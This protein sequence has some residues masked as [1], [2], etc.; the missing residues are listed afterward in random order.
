M[1]VSV[2]VYQKKLGHQVEWTTLGLGPHTRTR[3]GKHPYKVQEQLVT[4]L[5]QVIAKL[6]PRDLED[7]QMARGTQLERV[8]VELVLKAG[9]KRKMTGAVPLILEPRWASESQRVIV[10]YHPARQNEWFPVDEDQGLVEQAASFFAASWAELV[11]EQIDE[12]WTDG[13][14]L[15]K[16]VSFT[17]TPPSLLEELPKKARG[18]WDDLKDDRKQKK[19]PRGGFKVLGDIGVNMTA[20]AAEGMLSPGMARPELREQLRLVL[21]AAKKVPA[22]LVGEP[23]SGKTTLLHRGIVDLL[24][25]D[26]Y[27]AH[28]NLDRV[29][30]VWR[31]GG[32]GII[33]GMTYLGDWEQ[34]CV[35]LLEDVRHRKIVLYVE[36]IHQLGRIGRSRDSERNLAEVFRG[37]L[38]RGELVMIGECTPEQLRQLEEDAPAFAAAFTRVHVPPASLSDTFRMMVHEVREL[39]PVH[40]VEIEPTALRAVLELGTTFSSAKALPG[41]AVDLLRQVTRAHAGTEEKVVEI[42][43]K[44]VIMQLAEKTGLPDVLLEPLHPLDPAHVEGQLERR[45]MGQPE[46][47]RA[48]TDLIV[49]IKTGLVDPRRPYGVYLFAGPTGTGKTELAKAIA[50]Y[51]YGSASRLLRLDMSE[52]AT[53]DAAARLIGDRWSPEGLL[54]QRV[55][56][57]PFSVVLFDEIE[58]AHPQV[59]NLLLQLFDE[60]RLTDAAGNTASFT[61]AVV[62]MTS[63]LGARARLPVGFGEEA[64]QVAAMEHVKAVREFFP[65]ELFNRIDRIVPFSPITEAVARRIA[66]KE[67]SRLFSR[68]GLADRSVFVSA[69][70]SVMDRIVREAFDA[71]DGARS[72]KRYLEDTIGTLLTRHLVSGPPAAMQLVR[73]FES[74]G[75]LA[76]LS[77]PL[78]ERDPEDARWALE[79]ALKLAGPELESRVSSTLSFLEDLEKSDDL[80][81][82][83]E[84][85]REHLRR[86][87]LGDRQSADVLYNLETMRAE[88][89][90]FRAKLEQLL[91]TATDGM[92]DLDLRAFAYGYV[93]GPRPVRARILEHM[94]EAHFLKRA[95]RLVREADQHA[96]WLELLRMG[97]PQTPG[98][99][100][101]L[102]EAYVGAR[103]ICEEAAVRHGDRVTRVDPRTVPA[104]AQEVWLKIVGLCVKDFYALE[105]GCHVRCSLAAP[106]EI[107]RVRVVA[108]DPEITTEA[109]LTQRIA[110]RARFQAAL[111]GGGDVPSNPDALTPAV[112]KIQ[113]DPP[114]R[115]GPLATVDIED[116]ALGTAMTLPARRLVDALQPLWLLRMSREESS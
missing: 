27:D 38:A 49:R 92:E 5:R 95:V 9:S 58:K 70:P 37:P 45:V 60:G 94:G 54:T 68:R 10:A 75:Q 30:A 40:H 99:L 108:A 53:P 77:E 98:L 85:I 24:S 56:E 48:A 104:G 34:R 12:L 91:E 2:P 66:G 4:E 59:H 100:E 82:L 3:R 80:V 69:Q 83:S 88:V 97:E 22:L 102:L 42:T 116:Y 57:Q 32:K 44:D 1:F 87:K 16:V 64:G 26:D 46:A 109:A 36:D 63:N 14:D 112:R 50:E 76:V 52:Y 67:L 51:L 13:K 7:F 114:R 111:E 113:F 21:C 65:P 106:P 55:R 110:E 62:L 84:E 103:G 39:E 19:E 74:K 71:R 35:D 17:A 107:V 47:I 43:A 6:K 8:K 33:A 81:R 78:T 72:V 89:Q 73:I 20:H 41:K 105:D 90:S 23:G 15:I 61:H 79:P 96:V 11:D 115:S 29:H 101:W 28:K 25:A 86:H 31:I 93:H 18:I